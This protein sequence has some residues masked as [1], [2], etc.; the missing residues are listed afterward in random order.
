[1]HGTNFTLFIPPSRG[2]LH[3]TCPLDCSNSIDPLL[4]SSTHSTNSE[5]AVRRMDGP[6]KH[7]VEAWHREKEAVRLLY[8]PLHRA[9]NQSDVCYESVC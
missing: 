2:N 1:M 3:L 8:S 6:P 7:I 9:I 5:R 4:L